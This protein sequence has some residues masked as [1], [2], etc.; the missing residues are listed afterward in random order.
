MFGFISAGGPYTSENDRLLLESMFCV[1]CD[2]PLP[3]PDDA[4]EVLDHNQVK[5]RIDDTFFL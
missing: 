2:L 3:N 5:P 4:A 1:N